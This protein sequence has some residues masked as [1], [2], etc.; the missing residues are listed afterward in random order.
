MRPA[1]V[2]NACASICGGLLAKVFCG[3]FHGKVPLPLPRIALQIRSTNCFSHDKRNGHTSE[4]SGLP[5]CRT[6]SY[7]G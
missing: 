4:G 7:L 2:R 5:L 3:V 1:Q 6:L